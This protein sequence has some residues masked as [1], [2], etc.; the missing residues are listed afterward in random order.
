MNDPLQ[1]LQVELPDHKIVVG[2]FND[3][4]QALPDAHNESKRD[5]EDWKT[6]VSV[7]RPGGLAKLKPDPRNARKHNPRNQG[8]IQDSIQQNGFG[9][10]LLVARDGTIIAGNAT[11]E[12]LAAAGMENVIE[13]ESDGTKAIVVRRTDLDP[14]DPKAVALAIADNRAAE[15]ATWDEVRVQEIL[16]EFPQAISAAFRPEELDSL[17]GPSAAAGAVREPSQVP[18]PDTPRSKDGCV[19]KL[20]EHTLICGDST[21]G[22]TWNLLDKYNQDNDY[23]LLCTDP[24]YNFDIVGG[25]RDPRDPNHTKGGRETKRIKNDKV[26][27]ADY[28][29]LLSQAFTEIDT[30]LVPGAGLYVFG[31]SS[32]QQS[33]TFQ[34]QFWK[35]WPIRQTIV[36]IKQH[37]VFGRDDYHWKHEVIYYG[38]KGGAR[39]LAVKDRTQSTVWEVSRP[40]QTDMEHP[41]QKPVELLALIVANGAQPGE[42]VLDPFA[43]AGSTL[44]ACEQLG[45]RCTAIEIDPVYTDLCVERWREASVDGEPELLEPGIDIPE[46]DHA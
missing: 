6:D 9:R 5:M 8:M 46:E 26:S 37:F 1:G 19:W 32:G 36:W 24:P 14:D 11:Y 40:T 39:H 43:G 35:L 25:V 18:L 20:G 2:K 7:P 13:V 29:K 15:L 10:S 21:R 38:W 12:A 30:R 42:R 23:R 27:D 17:L 16:F 44:L 45:R 4:E 28:A 41:S 22:Y 3:Q 31:P 33:M 34:T